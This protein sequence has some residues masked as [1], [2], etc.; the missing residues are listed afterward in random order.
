MGQAAQAPGDEVVQLARQRQGLVR[1]LV[2][3]VVASVGHLPLATGVPP[4]QGLEAVGKGLQQ[5]AQ[6]SCDSTWKLLN[7]KLLGEPAAASLTG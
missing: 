3:G 5:V 4:Q 6:L 1:G 7:M 2:R